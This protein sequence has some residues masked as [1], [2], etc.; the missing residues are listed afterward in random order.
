MRTATEVQ[1][2]N[3]KLARE[4]E[5]LRRIIKVR[6]A[7][8]KNL[9]KQVREYRSESDMWRCKAVMRSEFPDL[10]DLIQEFA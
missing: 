5:A 3:S 7:R 4:V 6:D 9:E 10:E 2:I 8:I 1:R